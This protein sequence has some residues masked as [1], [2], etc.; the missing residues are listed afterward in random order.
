M[1][2]LQSLLSKEANRSV[3][4]A[5]LQSEHIN[6]QQHI[7]DLETRLEEIQDNLLAKL[8]ALDII[9][10]KNADLQQEIISLKSSLGNIEGTEAP[11]CQ[12]PSASLQSQHADES[13]ASISSK[14]SEKVLYSACTPSTSADAV[15]PGKPLSRIVRFPAESFVTPEKTL[16]TGSSSFLLSKEHIPGSSYSSLDTDKLGQGQDYIKALFAGSK[17]TSL[18]PV[19]NVGKHHAPDAYLH[20]TASSAVGNLKIIEVHSDGHYVKILNSSPD[21][22]EGIG[23]YTLQ[24]NLNGHPVAI[25]R[26][27]PKIR[28]KATAAITVWAACSK[29]PHK[30]PDYLWKELE[31]FKSGPECTTI[32]CN[33]G[34]QAVAWYTPINWSQKQTVEEECDESNLKN[35]RKPLAGVR[36]L[37]ER[38]E[39]RIF[40]TLQ[41][42]ASQSLAEGKEPDFIMREEKKPPILNPVQSSWCQSPS[43]PTHPHYSVQRQS[44]GR[45]LKN[46][47]KKSD[48]GPGIQYTEGIRA[49]KSAT[50]G[51]SSKSRARLTRSAGPN[52]GGVIYVGSAAPIGSAL[53]KYFAHSSSNFSLLAHPPFYSH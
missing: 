1:D 30:P 37:R 31:K 7:K 48:A 28:M 42:L 11:H 10:G 44:E 5:K 27:P 23:D 53:Q 45:H 46:L 33:P 29:M 51:G 12:L 40:N 36:Q 49:I 22:E 6:S 9:Q 4:I 41:T 8:Q 21:K 34:G 13:K 32:L 52:L 18:E 24:Q 19:G 39:T 3:A 2:F 25:F 16:A 15:V 20:S 14:S 38:S 43:S 17:K 50:G 47:P 26:F 35:T